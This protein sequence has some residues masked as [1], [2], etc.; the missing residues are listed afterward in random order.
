MS[1][2]AQPSGQ[3]SEQSGARNVALAMFGLLLVA[4]I[5]MAA[6]RRLVSMLGADIRGAL[7]LSLPQMGALSGMFTLGFAIAAIP[8]G[9]LILKYSRKAVLIA[10]VVLFSSATLLFTQATGFYSMFVFVVM[11]G[12]GMGF[13]ATSMLFSTIYGG[14]AFGGFLIGPLVE[15]QGWEFAGQISMSLFALII[16]LLTFGLR[17]DQMSK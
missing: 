12:V 11:Q 9:E 3:N 8:A 2:P 13:L 17:T 14:A 15:M 10:G 7:N 1:Q 5:L 6:D 4:C 16:A